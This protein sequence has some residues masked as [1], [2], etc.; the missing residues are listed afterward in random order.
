[1]G[2][3]QDLESTRNPLERLELVAERP[4]HEVRI[5]RAFYLAVSATTKAQFRRFVSETEFVTDA[6]SGRMGRDGWVLRS[7][8]VA[9]L[10]RSLDL[11]GDWKADASANW[12]DPMPGEP[13]AEDEDA[14]VTQVDYTDAQ[15]FCRHYAYR[16]P[17][18]AEYEFAARAGTTTRYWWGDDLAG[19]AGRENLADAAFARHFGHYPG[20]AFAFDDGLV[21]CAATTSLR[22]NSWGL[23]DMTGNVKCW[24]ADAGGV[25]SGESDSGFEECAKAGVVEDPRG[26]P[27]ENGIHVLR[28]ASWASS[29][30]DARCSRRSTWDTYARTADVGFRCACTP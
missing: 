5:T 22:A 9:K 19:G 18:D 12:R 6:E 28:G 29:P 2:T 11:A 27:Y 10:K 8:P 7:D 13:L 21:A 30:F 20:E 26:L 23:R 15:A 3:D 25:V 14:P 17:T 16:L 1:M 4:A 24:C